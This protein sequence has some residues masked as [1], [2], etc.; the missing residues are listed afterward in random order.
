MENTNPLPYLLL[1]G[2][3]QSPHPRSA[4]RLGSIPQSN[5]LLSFA[6]GGRDFNNWLSS[7][8]HLVTPQQTG[9][10]R[11]SRLYVSHVFN[12]KGRQGQLVDFLQ[13]GSVFRQTMNQDDFQVVST[14]GSI[15][16]SK[17]CTS[18]S[19][20]WPVGG[21]KDT[22]PHRSDGSFSKSGDHRHNTALCSV[23]PWACQECGQGG[24][25]PA[26]ATWGSSPICHALY[27]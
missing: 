20:K 19:G 18:D 10:E 25:G 3:R 5:P 17:A 12:F 16:L 7:Y 22:A 15:V 11:R 24:G 8:S 26:F 1:A 13:Y 23:A 14:I 21:G 6:P 4:S 2:G 27:L 9:K